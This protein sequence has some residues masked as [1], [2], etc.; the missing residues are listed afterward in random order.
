[1]EDKEIEALSD[2]K[3]AAEIVRVGEKIDMAE[4]NADAISPGTI[5]F[6]ARLTKEDERRS[7]RAE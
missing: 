4:L 1:M 2:L 3:L 6:L 5:A 7:K